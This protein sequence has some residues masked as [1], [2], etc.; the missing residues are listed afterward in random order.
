MRCT[1]KIT[2]SAM[3]AAIAFCTV[4]SAG[5]SEAPTTKTLDKTNTSDTTAVV[6][7]VGA[8]YTVTIPAAVS[9]SATGETIG[10]ISAENVVLSN[11]QKILVKLTSAS[12]TTSGNVFHAVLG[13]STATYTIKR[14]TAQ[15]GIGDT[16]NTV[17][18][19]SADGEQALVFSKAEGATRAGKHSETLTFGISIDG[20]KT[21]Q[22]GSYTIIYADGDTWGDIAEKNEIV[23]I[24]PS[25]DITIDGFFLIENSTPINSDDVIDPLASYQLMG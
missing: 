5:A 1:K 24:L 10:T 22:I 14:G 23:E 15:I 9:L 8:K 16:V 2:A 11:N 17:A 21:L 13:D 6:Y 3:A 18:D 20:E 7:D 12:N 25:N 4:M 19:F